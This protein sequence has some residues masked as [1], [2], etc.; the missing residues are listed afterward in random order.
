MLFVVDVVNH[1]LRVGIASK[2]NDEVTSH[3]SAIFQDFFVR[4]TTLPKKM[5]QIL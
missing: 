3:F 5:W 2:F 1:E 4:Q